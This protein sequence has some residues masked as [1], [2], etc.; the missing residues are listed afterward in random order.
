MQYV[1]KKVIPV[2][3][4]N[5]SQAQSIRD[6]CHFFD[7]CQLSEGTGGSSDGDG[8]GGGGRGGVCFCV[9][10]RWM[11]GRRDISKLPNKTQI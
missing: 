6:N 9:S 10:W 2:S 5:K 8:D 7:N 1:L 11:A 4:F 3:T